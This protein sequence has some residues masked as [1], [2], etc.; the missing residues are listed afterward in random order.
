MFC[1]PLQVPATL[2]FELKVIPYSCDKKGDSEGKV[3]KTAVSDIKSTGY[4][5]KTAVFNTYPVEEVQKT[6]V[7]DTFQ[8][9]EV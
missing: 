8:T 6:V 5:L 4:V 7:L 3:S 9:E 1:F 2:D